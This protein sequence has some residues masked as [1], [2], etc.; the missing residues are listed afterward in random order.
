MSYQI[1][2]LQ[3]NAV[4]DTAKRIGEAQGKMISALV[5]GHRAVVRML[6]DNGHTMIL[7][8]IS[9]VGGAL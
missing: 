6:L 4:L 8:K 2:D 5:K 3:T 9:S 7:E 1:I